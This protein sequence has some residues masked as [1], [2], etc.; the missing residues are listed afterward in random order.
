MTDRAEPRSYGRHRGRPLSARQQHLLDTLLPRLRLD[1]KAPPPE[2]LTRA[3]E[4]PVGDVW[5]EIGFG[6]GEHLAWQAAAHPDVGLIGC[7]PFVNGVARLVGRIEEAGLANVRLHDGD[8][9]AVLD[10]LPDAALGR[11]FVLFPDPWPKAR[12]HKRR[13]LSPATAARLARVMRPGAC[14]RLATDIGDYARIS[15]LALGASGAFEWTA[16]GPQDWRVRA[17]DW[18]QTRYE[19]KALK[20]GRRPVY[21]IFRRR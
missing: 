10:W 15:L 13:L 5:L 2:P 1:L 9:L 14:L 7:E 18:P 8:A 4:A 6:A 17:D 11:V 16:Q 12:H 20:E 19:A 21:L 3:F